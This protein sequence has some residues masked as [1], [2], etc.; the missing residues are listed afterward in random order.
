MW[1]GASPT[2]RPQRPST[3]LAIFLVG[4]LVVTRVRCGSESARLA[5]A[6]IVF[7]LGLGA[8]TVLASYVGSVASVTVAPLCGALLASVALGW[9]S[10]LVSLPAQL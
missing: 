10:L 5:L 6:L 8:S 9:R 1:S 7:A 4:V 2:C 3:S